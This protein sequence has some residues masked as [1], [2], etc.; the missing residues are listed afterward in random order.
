V[1]RRLSSWATLHRWRGLDGPFATPQ[2]RAAL[3]LAVRAS[4]RPRK[5]KSERGVTRDVFD[6]LLAT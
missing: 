6:R 1:R 3:R 2:L 5:R 4:A